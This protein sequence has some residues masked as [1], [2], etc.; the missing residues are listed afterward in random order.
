VLRQS[1]ALFQQ[2]GAQFL[3]HWTTSILSHGEAGT[4]DLPALI[5]AECRDLL[6]QIAEKTDR[7]DAKTKALKEL[8]AGTD[9]ARCLQTMPGV[10]PLTALAVE[11]F[12][13][14]MAQF[15]C[16]RDFAAWLRTA[17]AVGE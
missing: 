4:C 15:R 14:D 1:G 13:P 3:D 11:A 5:T 2:P 17:F 6:A 16:G 10:G 9:T 8:A 7:I 12:A